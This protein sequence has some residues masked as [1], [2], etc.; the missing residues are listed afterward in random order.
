MTDAAEAIRTDW[1]ILAVTGGREFHAASEISRAVKVAVYLPTRQVLRRVSGQKAIRLG[2][3]REAVPRPLYP[4]YL[5]V[6]TGADPL[7]VELAGEGRLLRIGADLA[8]VPDSTVE[9]IRRW[10]AY[11]KWDD[12]D[13]FSQAMAAMIGK[14]IKLPLSHPLAGFLATVRQAERGMLTCITEP[15]LGGKGATVTIPADDV[16]VA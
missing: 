8:K 5:F 4:G 11:G 6:A 9:R 15:V 2:I 13:T 14:Q 3:R 7:A 10:Q 1:L 12:Q 16:M